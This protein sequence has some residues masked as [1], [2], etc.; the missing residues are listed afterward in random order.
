MINEFEYSLSLK[1]LIA[2][3]VNS[4]HGLVGFFIGWF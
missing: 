4:K 3:L 2:K 1:M